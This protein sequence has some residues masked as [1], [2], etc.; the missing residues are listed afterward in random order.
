[1]IGC[2]S[3]EEV[4]RL[5]GV[6]TNERRLK[7]IKEFKIDMRIIQRDYYEEIIINILRIN[8]RRDG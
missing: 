6:E 5:K 1:M 7:M 3:D 4:R 8:N 2:V